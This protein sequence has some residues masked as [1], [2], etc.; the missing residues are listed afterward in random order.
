MPSEETP[1]LEPAVLLAISEAPLRAGI[2]TALVRGGLRVAAETASRTEALSACIALKPHV[3][4]I[5]AELPGGGIA[6]AAEIHERLPATRTVLMTEHEHEDELYEALHAGIDGYLPNTTS[7]QRLPDAVR[8]LAAGEAA[9]SRRMTAQLMREQRERVRKHRVEV[10]G[11][12]LEVELTAREFD[13]LGRLRRGFGTSVIAGQLHISEITARRHIS[14]VVHKL[15][16]ANR[17]QVLD[18][19]GRTGPAGSSDQP[20]FSP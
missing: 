6:L 7:A 19:L 8:A 16:V 20:P 3:C 1:G 12:G 2:R 17:Q 4:I 10:P 14:S 9:L 5:G 11:T 18:L 13:V 15:G